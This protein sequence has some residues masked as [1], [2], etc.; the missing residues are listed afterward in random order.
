M[1]ELLPILRGKEGKAL[2]RNIRR[3]SDLLRT[4][5]SLSEINPSGLLDPGVQLIFTNC[6]AVKFN[7]GRIRED[8]PS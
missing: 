2:T 5:L 3:N 6:P 4:T 7:R 1:L 8:D